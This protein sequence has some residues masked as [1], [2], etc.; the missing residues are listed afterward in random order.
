MTEP[1]P[2]VAGEVRLVLLKVILY[3]CSALYSCLPPCSLVADREPCCSNALTQAWEN[4]VEKKHRQA[5]V[6]ISLAPDRVRCRRGVRPASNQNGHHCF[7]CRTYICLRKS[8][9]ACRHCL[10]CCTPA[11]HLREPASLPAASPTFATPLPRFK[12]RWWICQRR[13]QLITAASLEPWYEATHPLNCLSSVIYKF[14]DWS[15]CAR[16]CPLVASGP[17]SWRIVNTC[18]PSRGTTRWKLSPL[19]LLIV[20]G[21][22]AV[23]CAYSFV[24]SHGENLHVSLHDL[25][26]ATLSLVFVPIRIFSKWLHRCPVVR[27]KQ[28][29]MQITYG[30]CPRNSL[31]YDQ[32]QCV[33]TSLVK[34]RVLLC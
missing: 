6:L 24:F 28:A 15:C 34:S 21:E 1:L 23:I 10:L 31:I 8:A 9:S 32:P 22:H 2:F 33:S 7:V 5:I 16:R 30:T 4:H 11:I 17:R 19:L 12:S 20:W 29:A 18:R 3:C 14:I 25:F 13:L 27:A 26:S